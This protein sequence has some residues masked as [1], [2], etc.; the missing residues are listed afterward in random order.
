M[1]MAT[2]NDRQ[3]STTSGTERARGGHE[4]DRHWREKRV[5][6]LF[7]Q[8][9][10]ARGNRLEANDKAVLTGWLTHRPTPRDDHGHPRPPGGDR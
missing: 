6:P 4:S 1:S 9:R 7:S 5:S 10:G 2:T 8:R 3:L